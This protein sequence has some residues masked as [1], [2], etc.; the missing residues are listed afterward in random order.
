LSSSIPSNSD[1]NK[2]ADQVYKPTVLFSTRLKNNGK[3]T[4]QIE[5]ILEKFSQAK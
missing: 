4:A 3:Q 5:K 2:S 1:T